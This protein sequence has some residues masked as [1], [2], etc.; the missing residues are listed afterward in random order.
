MQFER[1]Y[2][3]NQNILAWFA[4]L[5]QVGFQPT[6]PNTICGGNKV[7]V[8][9]YAHPQPE[10]VLKPLIFVCHGHGMQFERFYILNIQHSLI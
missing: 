9:S 4:N 7:N 2:S 8:K 10:K 1:F 5:H 3:L 6:F